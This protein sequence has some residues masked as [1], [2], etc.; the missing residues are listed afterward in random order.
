MSETKQPP[1]NYSVTVDLRLFRLNELQLDNLSREFFG[2]PERALTG[3]ERLFD[4]RVKICF[5]SKENVGLF[6]S[7]LAC[8]ALEGDG[9]DEILQ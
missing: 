5:E 6:L 4:Q 8:F 1:C 9:N 3:E 2:R 7:S